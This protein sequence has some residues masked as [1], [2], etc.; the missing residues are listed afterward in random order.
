MIPPS[1]VIDSIISL[2]K[3]GKEI[4]ERCD[5]YFHASEDLKKLGDRLKASIFVLEVFQRIMP[6]VLNSLL[7]AQQRDIG[8]LIDHLQG[9][10][11]KCVSSQFHTIALFV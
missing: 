8:R 10:F 1:D 2:V 11:D 9:V 4:Y 6:R 3:V 5:T 7:P